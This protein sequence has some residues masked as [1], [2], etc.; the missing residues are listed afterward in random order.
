[1]AK[2][3]PPPLPPQRKGT[4]SSSAS[5]A[6]NA[7]KGDTKPDSL[8]ATID[9]LRAKLPLKAQERLLKLE[10]HPKFIKL[11]KLLEVP[12]NASI[13]VNVSTAATILGLG[14]LMGI[15]KQALLALAI[16]LLV[17]G[18]H[19]MPHMSEKFFDSS[20][21]LTHIAVMVSSLIGGGG[22]RSARQILMT[23]CGVMWATRL[24]SFL[25]ARIIRD[26]EDHRF[27][28]FKKSKWTFLTP[29]VVQAMWV[30]IIDL[31]IV[32]VNAVETDTSGFG[33]MDLVGLTGFTASFLLELVADTEKMVFRNDPANRHKFITDGVWAYSRH[34][35]YLGEIGMWVSLCLMG[36]SSFSGTHW[37]AWLSPLFT[38]H[39]LLNVTG[40]A[41]V[42]K[43]GFKKWGHDPA[44]QHY[45][46]HTQMLML[47]KPAPPF[48]GSFS[49]SVSAAAESAAESVADLGF[50]N[51]PI[52]SPKN[53]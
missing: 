19:G 46:K 33:L 43:A 22:T 15:T 44:Y 27:R 45:M 8:K 5:M 18:A 17:Y 40:V 42:E 37:L 23:V 3:T 4:G 35:N 26:K 25:Y 14:V 7:S 32:A 48:S 6:S 52:T 13:A 53:K 50:D 11:R 38:A 30:F 47:G 41:M 49:S 16:Q 2:S 10:A 21:S 1:M 20:G 28:K 36:S 34:P 12:D 51:N 39:L 31:P 24:G 9:K 29:W